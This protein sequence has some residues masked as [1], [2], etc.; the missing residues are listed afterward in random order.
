MPDG[1][2]LT[3][4]EEV[5]WRNLEL[6]YVENDSEEE[7]AFQF[8]LDIFLEEEQQVVTVNNQE[9]MEAIEQECWGDDD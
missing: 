5:D 8:P 6:W 3:V 9:E 1:S 7:P 4:S 2:F